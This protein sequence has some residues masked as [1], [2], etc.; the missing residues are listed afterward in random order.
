MNPVF[1]P[2]LALSIPIIAI[3]ARLAR[4]WMELKEKQLEQQSVLT[5]EKSAQYA[6]HVERLEH[7][8][9]V[10]ERIV[11]DRGTALSEQIDALRDAPA[12]PR[13]DLPQGDA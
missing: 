1:I 11:T 12:L 13:A 9:R 6:S 10:L 2:I 8:V 7:R 4:R 5:A 3:L